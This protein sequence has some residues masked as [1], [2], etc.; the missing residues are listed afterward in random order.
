VPV[1]LVHADVD[2]NV[3]IEHSDKMAAALKSAG[4]EV[5][6]IRISGLDHQID[7]NIQ[8]ANLLYHA[9]ALLDR[10]IGH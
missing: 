6:Y 3:N 9:G 10:T 5:E 2:T 4:K 1:L 7:D 8:R